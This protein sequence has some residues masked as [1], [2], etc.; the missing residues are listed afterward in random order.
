MT[1]KQHRLAG[2]PKQRLETKWSQAPSPLA[3]PTG[4]VDVWKVRLSEPARAGTYPEFAYSKQRVFSAAGGG[5][6]RG[7]WHRRFDRG[8]N[9]I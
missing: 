5:W 8:Q 1:A 9:L 7:F 2:E 4:R 6:N 3:F